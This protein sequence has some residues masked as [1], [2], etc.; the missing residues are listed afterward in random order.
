MRRRTITK[1]RAAA[2]ETL[3]SAGNELFA[4]CGKQPCEYGR[5]FHALAQFEVVQPQVEV[6]RREHEQV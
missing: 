5:E 2:L 6:I 1:S 3:P 4:S